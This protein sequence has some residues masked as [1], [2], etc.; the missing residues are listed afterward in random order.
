MPK[1]LDQL[2]PDEAQAPDDAPDDP[3]PEPGDP[4]EGLRELV[5]VVV[6]PARGAQVARAEAAE[7][8]GQEQV[9]NDQVPNDNGGQEERHTDRGGDPHA[10]PHGLDPLA[11]EDAEHDHKG[12]HEVDEVPSGHLFGRKQ[13]NVI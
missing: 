6:H 7:Q 1:A 5:G 3:L 10:I 4:V 12:V 8:Q 9:K 2:V 11:A 13:V